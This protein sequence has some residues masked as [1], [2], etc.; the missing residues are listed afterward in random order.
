M[1]VKQINGL[2]LG[3]LIASIGLPASADSGGVGTNFLMSRTALDPNANSTT[4][5]SKG[6]RRFLAQTKAGN[7]NNQGAN[8]LEFPTQILKTGV[9]LTATGLSANSMQLSENIGLSPVLERISTLRDRA[10]KL[11]SEQTI[12][13]LSVKQD[14]LDETLAARLIVQKASLEIDF[15]VAEIEAERQVYNE[16]LSTFKNDRDKA[17]ARTNAFAFISNGILW[18]V[19]GA[20][21][22]PPYKHPVYNIPAGIVGIPAGLVPSIASM[23]TFKQ[24]NGKKR[25]SEEEPNMLAKVFNYP[26]NPEIEY[27]NSVWTYLNQVPQDGSTSKKRI[28]QMI[29]RWIA[30]SNIPAFNDKNS[31]KQLDVITASASQ[32]KSLTI[33]TLTARSVMLDQLLAEVNKMKRMLLELDMVAVGDK[34]FIANEI[35]PSTF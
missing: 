28:D 16:L 11:G 20:L 9:S 17:L 3:A 18:A 21:F 6:Q 7:V 33:A 24:I 2:L 29:E 34:R 15:T 12:E 13:S 31:K 35:K 1:K 19:T 4:G 8:S 10:S 22:I 25:D 5:K 23:Y 26:T 30:D 14:L 27:P 32:K